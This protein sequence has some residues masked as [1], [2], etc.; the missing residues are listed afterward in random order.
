MSR[1]KLTFTM[2]DL[3]KWI[4]EGIISSE[5]RT[6][7]RSYLE[8][9]GTVDEQ[10]QEK[11]EKRKGLNFI[12]LAYYFGGFIILLAYTIFMGI[13]WLFLEYGEQIAISFGTIIALWGIGSFLRKKEFFTAGG[14]LI[15]V[16]TGIVP[17][18]I[19]TIQR[20]LGLWPSNNFAYHDFY[21]IIAKTWI[22]LELISIII[23]VIVIWRVRFPLIT[24]L[25]AFWT[26][27]FS[28]DITRWISQSSTWSISVIE[29]TTSIIIGAGMLLLGIYLQR[30]TAKDYSFWFYLFG[31]ILI[32]GFLSSLALEKGGILELV[33]IT[34]YLL[35]VI[36]SVWLQRR[37]F[38]VFGAMG[39]YSYLS[40]LAF[41]VFDSALGFIF[42]LG[43]I[44]LIIILSAVGYQKYTSPWLEEKIQK[45]VSLL[46]ESG[47]GK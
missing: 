26:W 39:I 23:S 4:E 10:S 7:I 24:L 47:K 38:L 32:F 12:S 44:G 18:L 8:S 46:Q 33:Y 27:F 14:L 30:K 42:S 43:G 16:G 22:P 36:A 25:I 21:R 28:M 20:M 15:F 13:E 17:L 31:H 3:E 19:V 37:I 34:V 29:Q 41:Q 40:Y 11:V 1:S 6:K 2:S 35:F 5:Q 9:K 45:D